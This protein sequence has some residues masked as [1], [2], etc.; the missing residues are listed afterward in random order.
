MRGKRDKEG[1]GKGRGGGEGGEKEERRR[2]E[3]HIPSNLLRIPRLFGKGT[4]QTRCCE[5]CQ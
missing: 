2:D 3:N 5:G 4:L 1:K